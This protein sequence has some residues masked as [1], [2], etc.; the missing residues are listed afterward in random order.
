[1]NTQ[2]RNAAIEIANARPV[3]MELEVV[4][5]PVADVDRS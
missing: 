5:I 2:V 1:M 3:D 4:V